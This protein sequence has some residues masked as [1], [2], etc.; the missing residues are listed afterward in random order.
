[1]PIML[2]NVA[3]VSVIGYTPDIFAPVLAGMLLDAYPGATGFQIYFLITAGLSFV[4][5]MAAYSVYRK[6][7][8]DPAYSTV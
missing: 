3:V 6:V 2:V 7:Q 5:L 1:M 8:R 4:G